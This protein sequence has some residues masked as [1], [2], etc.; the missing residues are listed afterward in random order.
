MRVSSKDQQ[1]QVSFMLSSKQ[2]FSSTKNMFLAHLPR[3]DTMLSV[4]CAI[5]V[6]IQATSQKLG[7]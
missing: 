2:D 5:T 1:T 7:Q 3:C 4:V 6:F